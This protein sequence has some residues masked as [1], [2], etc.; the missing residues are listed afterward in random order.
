M[1]IKMD[2]SYD[3]P[4]D[5]EI[6]SGVEIILDDEGVQLNAIIEGLCEYRILLHKDCT[7]T[8]H[9]HGENEKLFSIDL[10]KEAIVLSRL[11]QQF[12]ESSLSSLEVK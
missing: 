9:R 2:L 7:L 12:G 10:P 3:Y 1:G 8:V 6:E 5:N 11:C 4:I